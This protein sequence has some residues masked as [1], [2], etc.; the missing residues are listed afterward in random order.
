MKKLLLKTIEEIERVTDYFYKQQN[1]TGYS[2]LDQVITDI[3][4]TI[5]TIFKYR[6]E[7]Q[8]INFDEQK[9]IATLTEAMKAIEG[10]DSILLADIF[11][12]DLL[13]QF[14]DIINQL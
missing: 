8:T 13:E 2:E 1:Q 14:H 11:Q 12:Y 6:L 4:L 3:S 5:D 7:K 10:K 9:L